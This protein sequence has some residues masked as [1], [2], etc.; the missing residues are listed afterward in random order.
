MTHHEVPRQVRS[1]AS[2]V[3]TATLAVTLIACS[4]PASPDVTAPPNSNGTAD[5]VA[6]ATASV[7]A[8]RKEPAPYYPT[9]SKMSANAGKSVWF[10]ANSS[11]KIVQ[12]TA[13]AFGEAAAA[14]G[15]TSKS[16]F[17]NG[18]VADGTAGIQ[19]AINQGADG[20]VMMGDPSQLSNAIKEASDAGVSIAWFSQDVSIP[21]PAAVKGSIPADWHSDGRLIADWILADSGC[22]AKVGILRAPTVT[23]SANEAQGV[24]DRISELCPECEVQTAD[25]AFATVSADIP[26]GVRTIMTKQPETKYLIASYDSLVTLVSAA[27]TQVGTPDVKVIGHDGS[28]ENLTLVRDSRQ[29]VDIALPPVAYVGQYIL[30]N[31]GTVMA[32]STPRTDPLPSMLF[33]AENIGPSNDALFASYADSLANFTKA[34]R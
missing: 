31:L 29:A 18:S 28:P 20:I 14:A 27:L 32:G 12:D 15:M 23:S 33:D 26:N 2:A 22:D 1:I 30:D 6:T 3:L 21:L 34:W 25:I 11:F 13:S 24:I 9:D 16:Y 7:D 17:S 8:A 4:S 10:I 5:C 19:Q